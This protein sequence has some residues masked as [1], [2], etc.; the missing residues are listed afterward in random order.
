MW[1]RDVAYFY[2]LAKGLLDTNAELKP[3]H[4]VLF[5]GGQLSGTR[6]W[7]VNVYSGLIKDLKELLELRGTLVPELMRTSN[8]RFICYLFRGLA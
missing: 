3:L 6:D 4:E 7:L 5:K 8:E 2:N 1:S